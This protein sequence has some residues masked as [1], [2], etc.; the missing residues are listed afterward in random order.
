MTRVATLIAFILLFD[1]VASAT[2]TAC[3]ATSEL[4]GT[5]QVGGPAPSIFY[6]NLTDPV[7]PATLNATDFT[8]N[9][10]PALD[11]ELSNGSTRITFLFFQ[12]PI[13]WG[14]AVMHIPAGAFNCD[15]G[16]VAEFTCQ[17]RAVYSRPRRT[18]VPR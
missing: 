1:G 17:F 4:C 12:P 14:T 10:I 7:D 13:I 2:A 18:P 6:I 11:F 5:I 16:P 8:V 15:N 9:G 3:S